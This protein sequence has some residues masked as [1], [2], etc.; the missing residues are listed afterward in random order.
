MV[1]ITEVRPLCFSS[2]RRKRKDAVPAPVPITGATRVRSLEPIFSRKPP[3][4]V[5]RLQNQDVGSECLL[6]AFTG[7]LRSGGGSH[8]DL[9]LGSTLRSRTGPAAAPSSQTDQQLMA[10]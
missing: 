10:C 1:F 2:D 9:A 3:H 6:L 8:D 7:R 5:N 4:D